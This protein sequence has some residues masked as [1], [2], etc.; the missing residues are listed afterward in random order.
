MSNPVTSLLL[1]FSRSNSIIQ[2]ADWVYGPARN[3][4]LPTGN[5]TIDDSIPNVRPVYI[6]YTAL[7]TCIICF[8]F[9]IA[10]L[11][12]QVQIFSTS[13]TTTLSVCVCVCACVCVCVCVRACV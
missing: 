2:G 6:K 11:V 12:F 13:A 8:I 5:A 1:L 4:T 3:M 9:F 7:V 10:Y